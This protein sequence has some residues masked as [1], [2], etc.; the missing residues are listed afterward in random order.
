MSL[1]VLKLQ[2]LSVYSLTI[3]F[4]KKTVDKL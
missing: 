1:R 3:K 2:I 4:H